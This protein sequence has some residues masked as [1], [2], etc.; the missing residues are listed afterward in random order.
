M[1]HQRF[2][3]LNSLDFTA[4]LGVCFIKNYF[5][6]LISLLD[7]FYVYI[8]NLMHREPGPTVTAASG[9]ASRLQSL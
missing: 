5:H 3:F 4:C 8:L 6:I 2:F 9:K 7:C 1:S